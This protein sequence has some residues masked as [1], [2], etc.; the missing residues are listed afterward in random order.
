MEG[1]SIAL[2]HGYP[3][4][5]TID[6]TLSDLSGTHYEASSGTFRRIDSTSGCFVKY[7]E[8]ESL[9]EAP[10]VTVDVSGC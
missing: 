8:A 1:A 7:A 10:S 2:I 4:L 9:G 6:D 3:D 5:A